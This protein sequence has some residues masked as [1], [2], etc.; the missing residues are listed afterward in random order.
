M[1][2]DNQIKTL[3]QELDTKRIKTR[4]KANVT[5]SY[6]EGFDI[7]D[8]ANRIFG[9]GNWEYTIS[10]IE[11][12]SQETNQNQNIV[13]CYKA[14]IKTI[15]HDINHSKQISREDIGFGKGISKTLAEA[16]EGAAK[17]AVTDGL[18]RSL[19][20]FGNQLGLSLY[21]K[22]KNHQ[23]AI[24]NQIQNQSSNQNTQHHEQN[25]NYQQPIPQNQNHNQ[26]YNPNANNHQQNFASLY[27]LGLQVVENENNLIV[28]G[29]NIF[30][31]KDAIKSAGFHWDGINR[32]WFKTI[33]RA[34]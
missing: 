32:C 25:Q 7:I 29:E 17:E 13:V 16:H 28:V 18:K 27:N 1:F 5:L 26:N 20:S 2:N 14:I 10:K 33:E 22:S 11:Q 24:Q 15:V 23:Q 4:E 21:N 6:L 34:A 30:S 3:K 9:F 12:V 19:K 8:T 31:K